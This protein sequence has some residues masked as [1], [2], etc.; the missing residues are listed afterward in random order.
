MQLDPPPWG[1]GFDCRTTR[2]DSEAQVAAWR[3]PQ[4]RLPRLPRLAPAPRHRRSAFYWAPFMQRLQ[5][6]R[7]TDCHF[8]L[9]DTCWWGNI[10]FNVQSL[11]SFCV[12]YRFVPLTSQGFVIIITTQAQKGRIIKTSASVCKWQVLTRQLHWVLI[13]RWILYVYVKWMYRRVYVVHWVMFWITGK[14]IAFLW[15][16]EMYTFQ[17]RYMYLPFSFL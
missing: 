16:W 7:H 11:R 15:V 9:F 2:P 6:L 13:L 1:E 14:T 12:Y 4:L 5:K 8:P 10:P 3:R 17:T